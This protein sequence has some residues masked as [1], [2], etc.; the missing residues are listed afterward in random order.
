MQERSRQWE[1]HRFRC[2]ICG[3]TN[4]NKEQD[5][6]QVGRIVWSTCK[7]CRSALAAFIRHRNDDAEAAWRRELA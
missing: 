6:V 3:K 7:E 2:D 1:L 4:M 5:D